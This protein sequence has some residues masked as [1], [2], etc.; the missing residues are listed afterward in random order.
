MNRNSI[1]QDVLFR[2]E[3]DS[4][5]STRESTQK[6]NFLLWTIIVILLLMWLL[7]IF[8]H[9]G[10]GLIHLLLVVVVI[11]LIFKLV[12]GRRGVV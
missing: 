6:E 11:V 7:G 3:I 10:G 12:S 4:A 8:A 5:V 1:Q 9:I 2:M